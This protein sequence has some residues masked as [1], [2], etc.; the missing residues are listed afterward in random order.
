MKAVTFEAESDTEAEEIAAYLLNI[1]ETAFDKEASQP[2]V[3]DLVGTDTEESII[4]EP[5]WDGEDFR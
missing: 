1:Y 5:V 4:D 3:I 2:D